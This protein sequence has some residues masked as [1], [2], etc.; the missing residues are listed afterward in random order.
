MTAALC[1]AI[2]FVLGVLTCVLVY[3]RVFKLAARYQRTGQPIA[4][5]P[6]REGTAVPAI[7]VNPE[8]AAY[9]NIQADAIERGADE[10]QAMAKEHG[11]RLSREDARKQAEDLLRQTPLNGM[12]GGTL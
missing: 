9:R 2:G 6:K 8:A 7:P 4:D 3:E 10:L 1:M 11:H 12:M 5:D